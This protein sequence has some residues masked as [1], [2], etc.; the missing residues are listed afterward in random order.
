[1]LKYPLPKDKRVK[2]ARLYYELCAT[3]GMPIYL[4]STWVE[5]LG[6]LIR[7]KRKLC[8]DDMRLPWK[9]VYGLL[10]KELFLTRRQFEIKCAYARFF[11]PLRD[12]LFT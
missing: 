10:K 1:M 11:F 7:S 5:G 2:L 3:P 12:G 6:R 9:P 4:L 8:I